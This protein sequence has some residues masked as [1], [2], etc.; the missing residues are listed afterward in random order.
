[1]R[2]EFLSSDKSAWNSLG[3]S[4]PDSEPART[5]NEIKDEHL[6]RMRPFG[7]L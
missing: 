2:L 4:T 1:M 7:C 5:V 6:D 3:T